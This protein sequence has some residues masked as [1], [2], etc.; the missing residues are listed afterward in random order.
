MNPDLKGF[1]SA[2]ESIAKDAKTLFG[3]LSETQLNWQ[4]SAKVWSVGLCLEH[5]IKTNNEILASVQAR[6]DDEQQ[7]TIFERMAL[8]STFF[9]KFILKASQPENKRQNKA[10]KVFAPATSQV[11]ADVVT[12]LVENQ[13]KV[14]ALMRASAQ[15]DLEKTI[16]TS[17]VARFVTY[18]LWYAYKIIVTHERRHFAQAARVMKNADFPR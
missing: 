7:T 15:L 14:I 13:E 8:G 3:D 2:A 16:I 18:S 5:L 11:T 17:P 1:I 6:V 4:P 10:P 9:G 12:R